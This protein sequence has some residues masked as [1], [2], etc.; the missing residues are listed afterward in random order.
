MAQAYGARQPRMMRRA[1]RVGIWAA[2]IAGVPLTLLQFRGEAMLLAL[3]QDATAAALAGEY[4]RGLA[5]SLI[6]AWI[7]IAVRNFMSALNEPEPALWITLA[8]IPIN[9]V[10]A[11]ALIN[12]A[13]G[14][15][16]LG[17]MGAGVAT[18]VVNIESRAIRNSFPT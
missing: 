3:G 4:L 13:L 14:M 6:P 10:I 2:V 18:S 8:A 7:F 11:Y 16:R 1:L 17:I 9:G 5:W 12:G 15:P